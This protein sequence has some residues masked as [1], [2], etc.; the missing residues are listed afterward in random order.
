MEK[1][2]AGVQLFVAAVLPSVAICPTFS[3]ELGEPLLSSGENAPLLE[4]WDPS[5]WV[6]SFPPKTNHF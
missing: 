4:L 5:V 1:T 6:R 3:P 2:C